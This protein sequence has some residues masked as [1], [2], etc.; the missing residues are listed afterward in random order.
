MSE[1]LICPTCKK[2]YDKPFVPYYFLKGESKIICC[3]F[4]CF[5]YNGLFYDE[6]IN[7]DT[8]FHRLCGCHPSLVN[9]FK[10]E[11]FIS[12]EEYNYYIENNRHKFIINKSK[13]EDYIMIPRN[14]SLFKKLL[15]VI[16]YNTK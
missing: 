5:A 2:R 13:I 8:Y 1:I 14:L 15:F 7:V 9:R 12:D 16:K 3:S 6:S 10:E 11:K 4:I